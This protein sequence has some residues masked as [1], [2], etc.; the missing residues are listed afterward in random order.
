MEWQTLKVRENF[1]E[2]CCR[3]GFRHLDFQDQ[4][5]ITTQA[6]THR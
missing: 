1:R 5:Y 6:V 3:P 4:H 2:K